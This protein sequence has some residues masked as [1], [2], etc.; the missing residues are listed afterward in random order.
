[1]LVPPWLTPS[2][3][4]SEISTLLVASALPFCRLFIFTF[5]SF[6]PSERWKT[7]MKSRH[8]DRRLSVHLL[9]ENTNPDTPAG[10]VS[11]QAE[12]LM[13]ATIVK[14]D[15]DDDWKSGLLL[16][17]K[18]RKIRP[19]TILHYSQISVRGDRFM[20]PESV[21]CLVVNDIHQCQQM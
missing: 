12:L 19:T 6:F 9:E 16:L 13:D 18:G 15:E 2:M 21:M 8:R 5:G 14:I 1:M 7:N 4:F 3:T 10:C 11:F 20:Q 17:T